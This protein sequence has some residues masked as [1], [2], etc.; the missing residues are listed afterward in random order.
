VRA[1]SSALFLVHAASSVRQS[2][3]R[4]LVG[5]DNDSKPT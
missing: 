4:I 5:I 2:N 3:T 1:I